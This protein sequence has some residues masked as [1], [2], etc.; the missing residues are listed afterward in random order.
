MF[1]IISLNTKHWFINISHHQ[2]FHPKY[3]A[4]EEHNQ[5]EE[6][7]QEGKTETGTNAR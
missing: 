4:E 7:Q 6:D 1:V 3:Q 2:E 5:A